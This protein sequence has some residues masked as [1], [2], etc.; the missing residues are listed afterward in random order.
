M[1]NTALSED[2]AVF[3]YID[4]AMLG[5]GLLRDVVENNEFGRKSVV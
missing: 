3:A 2:G 4:D 1:M 5:G